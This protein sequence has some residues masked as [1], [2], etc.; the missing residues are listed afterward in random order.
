MPRSDRR[1]R[2]SELSGLPGGTAHLPHAVFEA[3]VGEPPE[4]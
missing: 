4:V 3:Y 2:V 1:S